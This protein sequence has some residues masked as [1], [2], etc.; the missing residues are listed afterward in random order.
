[1]SAKLNKLERELTAA[2]SNEDLAAIVAALDRRGSGSAAV[3]A[4]PGTARTADKRLAAK[5][6]RAHFTDR[7]RDLSKWCRQL[8]EGADHNA[9]EVGLLLLPHVYAL[10]PVYAQ[11]QLLRYADS[12]N[13][14]VREFA[15]SITGDIL[16]RHFDEFHPVLTKWRRHT[17]E[18][19]RRAVVIA[20]M[21]AAKPGCPGRGLKLLRLI[22]PL[23]ADPARYVR[24]NL[25]PFAI[26]LALLKSYPDETLKW[27]NAQ[28]RKMDENVRWNVAMVWSAV[29]GRKHAEEGARLLHRLAVDDRRF[30]WRSVASAVVKLGR[31]RPDVIKPLVRKW[32]IDPRRKH[33]AAVVAYYLK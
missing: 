5:L 12:P 8:L 3:G 9:H 32:R 13:W 24:V 16:D 30:V 33:A 22:E 15:G 17:S 27:L 2:L 10:H 7:P 20:A 4:D 25:G 6:I 29:G 31:A 1:M 14:E 18:N 23:M 26:S 21:E 19:V 28:S 11:R